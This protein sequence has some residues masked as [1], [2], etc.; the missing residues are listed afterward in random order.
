[1]A[2][3]GADNSARKIGYEEVDERVGLAKLGE[4]D[5]VAAK[6]PRIASG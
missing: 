3:P 2:L 1:L 5:D 6:T 4:N